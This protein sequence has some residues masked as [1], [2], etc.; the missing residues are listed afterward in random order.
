MEVCWALPRIHDVLGALGPRILWA[1]ER[2]LTHVPCVNTDL[3]V[4]HREVCRTRPRIHATF[5]ALPGHEHC[6]WYWPTPGTSISVS[7]SSTSI[8]HSP[9]HRQLDGQ[10]DKHRGPTDGHRFAAAASVTSV[11]TVTAS[12]SSTSIGQSDGHGIQHRFATAPAPDTAGAL[13]ITRY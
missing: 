5:G 8:G 4:R 2:I 13:K 6:D 7:V 10:G 3:S 9:E 1:G 12:V 11:R